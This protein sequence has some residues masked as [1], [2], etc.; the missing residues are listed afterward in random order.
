MGLAGEDFGW[1][2]RGGSR[3]TKT[4]AMRGGIGLASVGKATAFSSTVVSTIALVK[5]FVVCE[6]RWRALI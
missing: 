5:S 2:W 4:P 3:T 6:E 1:R